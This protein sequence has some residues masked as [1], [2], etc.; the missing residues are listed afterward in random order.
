[1]IGKWVKNI[2]SLIIIILSLNLNLVYSTEIDE[3]FV[4]NSANK[5]DPFMPL[6]TKDGRYVYTAPGADVE[7][8]LGSITLE[9]ILKTLSGEYLAIINGEMVKAGDK[10][11]GLD[12]AE[13]KKDSVKLSADG[14]EK[15]YKFAE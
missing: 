15:I 1:M 14:K 2:L 7:K 3:N 12:V 11:M 13:I 6:V 4:Y 9:G 8:K 5:R 10:I